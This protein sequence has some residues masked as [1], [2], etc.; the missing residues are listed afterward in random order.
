MINK[1]KITLFSLIVG[2]FVVG[3]SD[4]D[5]SVSANNC[6]TYFTAYAEYQTNV[7][8]GTATAADCVTATTTLQDWCSEGCESADESDPI[9]NDDFTGMDEAMITALCALQFPDDG[10]GSDDLTTYE[11]TSRFQNTSSVKYTGQT[12]R[13][14]LIRDIKGNV[15]DGV[16]AAELLVFYDNSDATAE[17]ATSS[18]YDA[19]QTL[20]HD[21]STSNL[22]GK[23]ASSS[24]DFDP[25]N[26]I[27]YD[28]TPDALVNAWFTTAESEGQET[29]DGVNVSQM[30]AK[31]LAAMVAYY[32]ATSVYFHPNKLDVADNT[33]SAN[34]EYGYTSME[35]YWDESFGYFGASVDYLNLSNTNQ[36]GAYDTD[37]S[38]SI[39]YK[40]EYNFD[41]AAYAA[42][43]DDCTG[44]DHDGSFASTI[45]GA[46]IDGREAITAGGGVSSYDPHRMTIVN[47]WEKVVAANIVHYANSVQEDIASG[48][49]DLNKHWS[50]MRAFGL[51]LQFNYYKVISDTDLTEMITLM[52]NAPS[53]DVSYVDTMEQVKTMIGE[54]YMFTANDLANW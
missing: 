18:S 44:C 14:L 51:A 15:A 37:M 19:D 36:R 25:G 27:G 43:R 40:T 29:S 24:F 12:V 20:Y 32:Q 17:I 16:T 21:I 38:G 47:T 42:K 28:M 39:D 9:C 7:E 30:V 11:F 3:C 5:D 46:Y 1:I 22:S 45:M 13:N 2:I 34:D 54:V 8:N 33:V 48:S 35:H 49:S 52:G 6:G 31:G 10:G 23:I 53:S 50:E 4:D 41:W 26:V